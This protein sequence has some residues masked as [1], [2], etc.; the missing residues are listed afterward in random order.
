MSQPEGNDGQETKVQTSQ[1]DDQCNAEHEARG[2]GTSASQGKSAGNVKNTTSNPTGKR[3][4]SNRHVETERG[5]IFGGILRQL[6][7]DNDGQLAEYRSKIEELEKRGQQLLALYE[8][9]QVEADEG[10]E[11]ELSDDEVQM[12]SEEE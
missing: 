7:A 9:L 10:E 5:K 2:L 11:D 8:Q 3:R 12:R 4:D 1:D 6:I